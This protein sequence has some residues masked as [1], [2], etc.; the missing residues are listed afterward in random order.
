[1]QELCD[2]CQSDRI[3]FCL[4]CM[5]GLCEKCK[6]TH[7]DN[8]DEHDLINLPPLK[9]NILMCREH[10]DRVYCTVGVVR[11]HCVKSVRKK[12]TRKRAMTSS[13]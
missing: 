7:V 12:S 4:K 10:D 1:M 6:D 3:C 11:F 2:I 13:K 8:E 9:P 5:V